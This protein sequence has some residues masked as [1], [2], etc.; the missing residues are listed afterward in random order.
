[1]KSKRQYP[2][3]RTVNAGDVISV[4]GCGPAACGWR[5]NEVTSTP[6]SPW[7]A[8]WRRSCTASMD[9]LR[10]AR[11]FET[12][13]PI[14]VLADISG[15]AWESMLRAIMEIRT[16]LIFLCGR[17]LSAMRASRSQ[18]RRRRRCAIRFKSPRRPW[19]EDQ[20]HSEHLMP[21][22]SLVGGSDSRANERPWQSTLHA[23]RAS[24]LASAAARTLSWSR[25]AAA[26]N[27][28]SRPSLAQFRGFA[29]MARPPTM[30]I[31]SHIF[32][33]ACS[34]HRVPFCR[35]WRAVLAPSGARPQSRG[36]SRRLR[37]CRSWRPLRS[38]PKDRSSEPHHPLAALVLGRE[39][40][41]FAGHCVDPIVQPAPVLRQF[42]DKTDHARRKHVGALSHHRWQHLAH[43]CRPLRYDN[44]HSR[45]KPRSWLMTGL[46]WS[47]SLLRTPCRA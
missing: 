37:H 23:M 26:L 46:P 42:L 25:L 29:S 7:R 18:V 21:Y 43:S 15:L 44:P 47:T 32:C 34:A 12:R 22:T 11:D 1:M 3:G 40:L 6:S 19:Q 38:R 24:L 8:S 27:H 45:R 41:D 20:R 2:N 31:V 39:R 14:S 28:P 16:Y 30:K 4:A 36:P 10:G 13:W 5:L 33:H 35:Q 17:P 9:R